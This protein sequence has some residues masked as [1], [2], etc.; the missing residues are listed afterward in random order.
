MNYLL[1]QKDGLI[2]KHSL[3]KAEIRIGRGRDNDIVLKDKAVSKNHCLVR[4]HQDELAVTDLDSRNG[5][6]VDGASINEARIGLN[7][8]FCIE[9]TQFFFKQGD[10]GEFAVS[11]SLAVL[12]ALPNAFRRAGCDKEPET[13][14]VNNRLEQTL[15]SLAEKSL[16]VD[17]PDLFF[18]QAGAVL[19]HALTSG[20]LFFFDAAPPRPLVNHLQLRADDVRDLDFRALPAET[21][22][23]IQG[24]PIPAWTFRSQLP[25]TAHCL[26][27]LNPAAKRSEWPPPS[28]FRHLLEIIEVHLKLTAGRTRSWESGSVLYQDD[29]TTIIGESRELKLLVDQ[30]KRFAARDSFIM[31]LGESGTGKELFARMI[32]GL[33][34]RRNFVAFNCAAIP[35]SLLESELFGYEKGA[36]TDARERRIGKIEASSGGTLVLDEIGDMPLDL[37]AKVL[38]VI[39]ERTITRLGGHE[40]VPV[41]LRI[42]ALSNQDLSARA[43]AGQFRRDL[44]FRLLVHQLTIPPLRRRKQD[45]P[46]LI[47]HFAARYAR[48]NA[49]VPAGFSKAAEESLIGHSWPGNVR[50]LENEIRRIMETVDDG[51]VIARHHLRPDLVRASDGRPNPEAAAPSSESPASLKDRVRRWERNEIEGLLL[52]NRGNKSQTARDMGITYRGFLLKLKRLGLF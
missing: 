49:V 39:Q 2:K 28:F 13:D 17:S 40:T 31:I 34:G 46:A 3:D 45:I 36:F 35:A 4:A 24:R 51:E 15:R 27:Y 25:E 5:T 32:H 21:H 41:D 42:L 8:S 12:Y 14:P 6:F 33:S 20:T 52:K 26:C 37:Q 1:Y 30:A 38:R 7:R 23:P 43:E 10:I 18:R 19:R 16:V 22:L 9:K 48:E 29:R 50:E 11:P 47:R 44:Y